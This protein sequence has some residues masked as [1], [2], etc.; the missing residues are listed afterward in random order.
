MYVVGS[1]RSGSTAFTIHKALEAGIPYRGELAPAHVIRPFEKDSQRVSFKRQ[2]HET[3]VQ[4]DYTSSEYLM[5]WENINSPS[6][7]Y[8]VNP[9]AS[10]PAVWNNACAYITR[11]NFRNMLKSSCNYLIKNNPFPYDRAPDYLRF[12][13]MA[14]AVGAA[15]L[16][17][18]CTERQKEIT[19]YEDILD[20]NTEYSY[21]DS[22]VH[23]EDL[24]GYIDVMILEL[25][26]EII[27][28]NI[29]V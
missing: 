5:H 3:G 29:I 12:H 7:M 20:R 6:S 8:L 1:S 9:S 16:L 13:I 25:R 10:S 27:N 19:W 22:Y 24:D 15:L 2:Y 21:Y 26:P 17:Q 4:P 28:Q 23:K 11:K 14:T 18:F